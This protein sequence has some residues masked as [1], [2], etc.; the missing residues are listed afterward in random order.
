MTL[1]P[2][3]TPAGDR[4]PVLLDREKHRHWRIDPTA[5][6]AF[7]REATS[8][9]V[10][11]AEFADACKEY[12]VAF[13][14][15]A[16]R[17]VVPV[18]ML[19]LRRAENLFVNAEGRWTGRYVPASVRRYPFLF[20]S[21]PGQNSVGVC[22]DGAFTEVDAPAGESLFDE[23]G[24][25]TP[26]LTRTIAFLTRYQ[27]ELKR[28]EQFCQ[29][30][31]RAG[32]LNEMQARA[33]LVDGRSFNIAGLLVVDEKKL[34]ALPDAVALTLFRAGE[35]HLV[36]LHL[37]SLSNLQTLVDGVAAR[38]SAIIPAPRP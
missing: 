18:A 25:D 4:R 31:D 32:V 22:I 38:P 6:S 27:Q 3:T 21:L 10:A 17:Q 28:T 19:G 5:G 2:P 1:G 11:A 15:D 8:V 20:A 34:M 36:S 13:S 37:A 29:R 30:L 14:R 26:F 12:A 7:A 9:P 33:D 23:S 24:Q 35:M 16:N